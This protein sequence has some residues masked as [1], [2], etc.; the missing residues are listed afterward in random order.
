MP[1]KE[2]SGESRNTIPRYRARL[3]RARCSGTGTRES[4]GALE[5]PDRSC[6][7]DSAHCARSVEPCV[8]AVSNPPR[9]RPP[10]PSGRFERD[11]YRMDPAARSSPRAAM[12]NAGRLEAPES[13]RARRTR[14]PRP[15][16]PVSACPPRAEGVDVCRCLDRE[17]PQALEPAARS[18][19]GVHAGD[20]G[21]SGPEVSLQKR[22]RQRPIAAQHA[23]GDHHGGSKR[24]A[25]RLR[26]RASHR[27]VPRAGACG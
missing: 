1:A 4:S 22:P 26:H 5:D 3:C 23:A 13:A 8:P 6:A 20:P 21:R 15:R 12:V 11:R 17:L 24:R 14:H 10:L 18:P 9:G 19:G 25:R 27:R 7:D 16:S 2:H